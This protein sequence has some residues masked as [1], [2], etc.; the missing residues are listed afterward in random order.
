MERVVFG[1]FP[2]TEGPN[3]KY[4]NGVFGTHFEQKNDGFSAK[5]PKDRL[6]MYKNDDK[7]DPRTGI[8]LKVFGNFEKWNCYCYGATTTS[9]HRW[10]VVIFTQRERSGVPNLLLFTVNRR[11]T[12]VRRRQQ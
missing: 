10:A 8:D 6:I 7:R 1:Y 11:A 3:D 12:E 2:A 4:G 5:R 9:L